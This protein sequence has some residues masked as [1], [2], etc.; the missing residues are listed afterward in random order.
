MDKFAQSRRRFITGAG[1]LTVASMLPLRLALARASTEKRLLLVTLRGGLDGLAA[2][3]PYRD[4][5][6]FDARGAMAM[7]ES[8]DALRDLDGFFALHNALAPLED[9]YRNRELLVLHAAATS[10]RGRSHFD[11]QD[12][13]ENGGNKPHA[14]S[15]GWLNRTVSRLPGGQPAIAIGP[16]VP[17]VLRGNAPV[18]SWAP[19]LL[20][21][22]DE[23]FLARVM[24]MYAGDPLLSEALTKSQ[25]LDMTGGKDPRVGRGRRAYV[26]MMKKAAA[27][28]SAP[29]GARIGSVDM[30]GWDTH[31]NQG[32]ENGRLANNLSILA[33]GLL[34]FRQAMGAAWQHTGVLVVTE[35]GRTVRGNG[36]GGTDHGTGGVALLLG[37]RI[38]GG[39][40]IGDWPGLSPLYEGREL[41]PAND[42]RSLLKGTLHEHLSLDR[43]V[44]DESIFPDSRSA[45]PIQGL[46]RS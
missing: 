26:Q 2:V 29:N 4:R 38:A 44:L 10:Y 11:A 8:G 1:M 40:V 25:A 30:G 31:A 43:A 20:P 36:T 46:W 6:Y 45:A 12:Q 16:A 17:L 21:D 39:R 18:T 9:L 15:T 22:V 13:L 7:P 34:A 41:M 37:G 28:L 3:V 5:S 14:W 42:L 33:E 24:H 32:T 23:D 19:S 27:F 35:F